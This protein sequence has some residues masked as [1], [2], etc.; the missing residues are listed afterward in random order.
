MEAASIAL[1]PVPTRRLQPSRGWPRHL[2]SDLWR[3]RELLYF[4]IWRD[5]KVR[6]KQTI[7]GAAWAVI[8]PVMTMVAFTIFFGRLAH[9]PSD[10][11]P[12]PLFSMVGLVPWTY[13]AAALSASSTSLAGYQHIV[14]KVYFPRLIVPLAAVVGPLVDFAIASVVLVVLLG[15][16]RVVPGPAVVWLPAFVLLAFA[17]AAAVGVWLAALNVKYRDLRY[18]VPFAVQLWL[19]ATP[20]VYP[21]S[22]V[23]VRWRAVYGLNPMAGVIEGFRWA[24]VGGPAPGAFTVVSAAAVGVLLA[25]GLVHFRRIEGVLADVV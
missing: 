17:A 13:F 2:L 6:Y 18:V 16:Y 1:P 9:V 20:V 22:L 21:A 23:P 8:Q 7:L 19:F 11:V 25:A 12:Y 24:L 14:S 3:Y 4:F 5:V 10:G 15:W